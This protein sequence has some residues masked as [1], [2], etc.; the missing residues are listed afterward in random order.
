MFKK[1]FNANFSCQH[2]L[3]DFFYSRKLN[4]LEITSQLFDEAEESSIDD[5]DLDP[6]YKEQ[7]EEEEESSDEEEVSV[8]MQPPVERA[9]GDTDRD[10]GN[11]HFFFPK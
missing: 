9:D 5:S 4:P 10:S 7:E 2:L 1:N 6:D 8:F 11:A 3:E